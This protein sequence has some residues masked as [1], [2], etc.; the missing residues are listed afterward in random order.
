MYRDC[1]NFTCSSQALL[2][3]QHVE[4]MSLYPEIQCSI[5]TAAGRE[6]DKVDRKTSALSLSEITPRI[7]SF[8]PAIN[9]KKP[10]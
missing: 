7:Q 6:D 10:I 3:V 1:F 5:C 4:L 9:V 8:I 2:C